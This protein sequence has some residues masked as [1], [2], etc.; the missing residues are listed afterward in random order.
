MQ[1]SDLEMKR[2]EEQA[3]HGGAAEEGGESWPVPK[4]F[5]QPAREQGC[6]P[7]PPIDFHERLKLLRASL[8]LAN[9]LLEPIHQQ[10]RLHLTFLQEH[11]LYVEVDGLVELHE[12]SMREA[13]CFDGFHEYYTITLLPDI[14]E[15]IAFAYYHEPTGSCEELIGLYCRT[16]RELE[17][18]IRDEIFE[19]GSRALAHLRRRIGSA[20]PSVLE[21]E[22]EREQQATGCSVYEVSVTT[23]A[24]LY[25]TRRDA[26]AAS[27]SLDPLHCER[28]T[29][30]PQPT[31]LLSA[32][33]R[34][35][36]STTQHFAPLGRVALVVMSPG[37][38]DGGADGETDGGCGAFEFEP[39]LD[40]CELQINHVP[41]AIV[42]FVTAF[43]AINTDFIE[44]ERRKLR[45]NEPVIQTTAEAEA[46][47]EAE[48]TAE[49]ERLSNERLLSAF[50]SD[51]TMLRETIEH[52]QLETRR[53]IEVLK[54]FR[55]HLLEYDRQ[56]RR[57]MPSMD[58]LEAGV[59]IDVHALRAAVTT[60]DQLMQKVRSELPEHL[61]LR[62]F[63]LDCSAALLFFEQC[64]RDG[65]RRI[66]EAAHE[67]TKRMLAETTHAFD[68]TIETL[69]ARVLSPAEVVEL[70]SFMPTVPARLADLSVRVAA[71]RDQYELLED[72]S[73]A[74]DEEEVHRRWDLL[75]WPRVVAEESERSLAKVR[76]R[77]RVLSGEL[78]AQQADLQRKIELASIRVD[79]LIKI[80]DF[81]EVDEMGDTTAKLQRYDGGRKS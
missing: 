65:R 31:S 19:Q 54:A 63:F 45:S 74:V 78:I 79:E 77:Q 66:I 6:E 64:C 16:I 55:E 46:E 61:V 24:A 4:F 18:Q 26:V 10:L 51:N 80:A 13:E 41:D 53:D 8:P 71:V 25:G 2:A 7:S 60:C 15:S 30:P 36:V 38:A 57:S 43:N 20:A 17:F 35:N 27:T 23:D 67:H 72:L 68:A 22:I 5:R 1:E 33:I 34:A 75:R 48:A 11:P 37:D 42:G 21:L 14:S 12:W 58:H 49:R 50:G 29:E 70:R 73:C 40:V 9:P 39:L 3:S 69:S 81:A 47:A 62:V 56:I 44:I 76:E 32:F 59:P 28:G 52:V